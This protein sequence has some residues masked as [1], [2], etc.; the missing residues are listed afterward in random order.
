MSFVN[1]CRF[2][3]VSSSVEPQESRCS[4]VHLQ[5]VALKGDWPKGYAREGAAYHGLRQYDKVRHDPS[6][7]HW[8]QLVSMISAVSCEGRFVSD[9]LAVLPRS[10]LSQRRSVSSPDRQWRRTRRDS[11]LIPP[12]R[13]AQ[14][15]SRTLKA[16][17]HAPQQLPPPC[18]LLLSPP[19]PQFW[20]NGTCRIVPSLI[21]PPPLLLPAPLSRRTR[22][23]ASRTVVVAA[24]AASSLPPRTL[25]S[26]LW[27]RARAAFSRSRTS[28]RLCRRGADALMHSHR[29]ESGAQG[30]ILP[31]PRCSNLRQGHLNAPR[32]TPPPPPAALTMSCPCVRAGDPAGPGR[33]QQAPAGPSPYAGAPGRP[34]CPCTNRKST[35]PEVRLASTGAA[36]AEFPQIRTPPSPTARPLYAPQCLGVLLGVSMQQGDT[37]M[38]DA[39]PGAGGQGRGGSQSEAPPRRQ[40]PQQPSVSRARARP[41]CCL[42]EIASERMGA[43][44]LDPCHLQLTFLCPLFSP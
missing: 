23:R 33:G 21:T 22:A 11:S 27:T 43:R 17:R 34:Q 38:P 10:K 30:R 29:W 32:L 41:K 25:P 3:G 16:P 44:V 12:T 19:A 20:R 14:L 40:A 36:S 5:T 42:G 6:S 37:D 39:P 7:M 8:W 35:S 9:E 13:R 4:A 31:T 1:S 26:L 18:K 24:W 28:R 2:P 15:A